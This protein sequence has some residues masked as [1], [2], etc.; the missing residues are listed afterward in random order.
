MQLSNS[1]QFATAHRKVVAVSSSLRRKFIAATKFKFSGEQP[2]RRCWFIPIVLRP[3]HS[4]CVPPLIPRQLCDLLAV[5][6]CRTSSFASR[7][8]NRPGGWVLKRKNTHT[9]QEQDNNDDEGDGVVA[10]G[11]WV[12]K[13]YLFV[14]VAS[15]ALLEWFSIPGDATIIALVAIQHGYKFMD[16]FRRTLFSNYYY[17]TTPEATLIIRFARLQLIPRNNNKQDEGTRTVSG[18]LVVTIP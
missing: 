15:D 14:V 7:R 17:C 2:E 4:C 18:G 16:K 9:F 6:L 1:L 3:F 8:N 11:S 13:S 5:T 12:G 10:G